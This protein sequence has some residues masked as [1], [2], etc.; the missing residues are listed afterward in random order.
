[1]DANL[2]L[3]LLIV[4][5]IP[6]GFGII[7]YLLQK[8]KEDGQSLKLMTEWVKQINEQ[9]QA[10]RHELQTRLDKNT[11]T[12]QNSLDKTNKTLGDRLDRAAE[13]IGQVQ[14][15]L[16]QVAEINRRIAEFQEALRAPKTRGEI[17]EKVM[18]DL[19]RQIIPQAYVTFQYEFHNGQKVDAAVKTDSGIIPIDSKFPVENFKRMVKAETDEEREAAKKDFHRDV[20]KHIDDIAKKYILPDEGTCDFAIMYITSESV[21]YEIVVN[22]AEL[23]DY[24]HSKH[25]IIVSPQQFNHFLQ[26][27]YTTLQVQQI[28]EQAQGILAMLK[29]IRIDSQK[30][31]EDFRLLNKHLTNAKSAAD[32]ATTSFNQLSGK[33]E[34]I[35]A[36]ESSKEQTELNLEPRNGMESMV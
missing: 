33:I 29:G 6:L 27:I 22:N 12:L 15:N 8:P 34:N 16:G 21:A 30:F 3:L 13:V 31:G 4:F 28:N 7:L 19:L 11:D 25:V 2:I 26:V 35:Q 9:T 17:G 23:S 32:N 5:L 20:K 1:M 24:A 18:Y 14:K 36:L 10:L